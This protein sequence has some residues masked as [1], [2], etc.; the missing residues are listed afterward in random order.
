VNQNSV[1][2]VGHSDDK[3]NILCILKE[4][5]IKNVDVMLI[6][7]YKEKENKSILINS[8]SNFLSIKEKD[9]LNFLIKDCILEPKPEFKPTP[10]IQKKRQAREWRNMSKFR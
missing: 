5:N 8:Y 4:K 1:I 2:L 7:E 9:C 10:T 6:D 3:K